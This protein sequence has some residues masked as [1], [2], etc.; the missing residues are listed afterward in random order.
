MLA[1]QTLADYFERLEQ[2]TSRLQ[3]ISLLAELFAGVEADEIAQVSYLLQGR[4]APF[5]EPVEFGLGEKSVVAAIARAYGVERETVQ[6]DYARLGDLGKV[7]QALVERSAAARAE[8]LAVRDVFEALG[9][10]AATTGT[11]SVDQKLGALAE[12]LRRVSPLAAKHLTRIPLGRTRLGVGDPTILA[13][14]AQAK[15]GDAKQRAG[16]E[17]AYN[18]TSDL[19]LIGRTLWTRGLDGVRAL[20]VS[21]GRPI[22]PQLAERLP[23][24]ATVLEKFGGTA[25]VQFK[26]DG[27]RIQVHLDRRQPPGE[28]VRLFSRNLEDMTAM[29]PEIS[30]GVLRQLR[31]ETAILDSEALGYNPLSDEFLPF[32]ETMRRRRKYDI[33]RM[34]AEL[35]LRAFAFDLM[36]RD[37]QSLLERPLQERMALLAETVQGGAAAGAAGDEAVLHHTEEQRS[38][39][40]SEPGGDGEAAA[41]RDTILAELGEIVTDPDRMQL[42]FEEALTRGLE[43]LMA[44]RTESPYQAG[45]RNFN[46]VKLK[47]H[48]A[49]ALDDT[50]DCVLLGTIFGRGKRADFGVGALL[51]GVYDPEADEF[52]TASKIGTGLSDERWREIAE[53]SEPLRRDAKP[54]RVSS[55]IVPTVWLEPKLVLEVLADEITRSPVHTAGRREGE[56]GYALRFPRFLRFRSEDRRPEDATT[57][58]ELIELYERQ[59]AGSRRKEDGTRS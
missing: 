57:V 28:Q 33:D 56:P 8:D 22:R 3:L 50:I 45:A 5:Y 15:L 16:L 7:A 59:S 26:L 27:F 10:V 40:V 1:F 35:P 21:V 20:D 42:L 24:P 17:E 11:G 23:D 32:Q 54:A 52:V 4:L 58:R 41:V 48:S 30:A 43:G 53:R 12:L 31:A 13:A 25:H 38:E 14:F 2:T 29:F 55:L 44:K 49:G 6:A 37:G 46:W 9:A 34:Q 18:K 36:Y 39:P 51:V 47:K 19:G